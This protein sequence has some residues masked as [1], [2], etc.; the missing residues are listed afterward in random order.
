MPPKIGIVAALEREVSAVTK[1][2][3]KRSD[4]PAGLTVFENTTVRLVCGGMGAKQAANA[5]NW[6]IASYKPEAV[7]SIGFAG[8]LVADYS[9]G[10]VITPGTVID[11]SN[12]ERFLIG[13]GD[14]ILVSSAG[15]MAEAGKRQLAAQFAA[16][17]V[18]MEAAAVARVAGQNGVPF[19][20]VKAIS[21][22][23]DFAMPPMDRFVSESG[24]FR[25]LPFL[26]YIAVRPGS[27]PVVAQLNANAHRASSQLCC[28]LE[29]Q[30]SRDFQDVISTI[31]AK[32]RS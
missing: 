26:A 10:D 29:N 1:K 22:P 21:D 19:M 16:Q 20:A 17:A 4:G 18:D 11:G 15:V 8:A 5:A 2:F 13:G 14:E 31:G 23:L 32:T 28:W 9:V 24:K 30:I 3:A 25:T 7:M 12:G 6:L 27:W